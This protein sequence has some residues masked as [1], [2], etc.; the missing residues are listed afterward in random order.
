MQ[1]GRSR[2]PGEAG[3]DR[4]A[5]AEGWARTKTEEAVNAIGL[6]AVLFFV[7]G[8][9]GGISWFCG[10]YHM[11]NGFWRSANPSTPVHRH[12]ALVAGGFFI[13]CFALAFLNGLIEAW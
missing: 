4:V 5:Q 8:W 6:I 12:K 2:V 11:L 3:A 9:T 1:R 7:V 10:V 13:A